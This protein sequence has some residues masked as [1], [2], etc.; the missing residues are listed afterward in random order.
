MEDQRKWKEMINDLFFGLGAVASGAIGYWVGKTIYIAPKYA[1]MNS[2]LTSLA[3]ASFFFLSFACTVNYLRAKRE[4][5][6]A[7]K[8][9]K[10]DRTY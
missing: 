9:I 2:E 8:E 6:L 1:S 3:F 7:K 4:E 10:R 5:Y